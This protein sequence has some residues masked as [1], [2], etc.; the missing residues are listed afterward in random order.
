MTEDPRA[1]IV[2]T[3]SKPLRL[4]AMARDCATLAPEAEQRGLGSLGYLPLLLE[5][6]VAG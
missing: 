2:S 6:K 4:P 3:Y 5:G 1:A